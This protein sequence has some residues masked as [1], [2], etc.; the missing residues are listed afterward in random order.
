MSSE[1]RLECGVRQ[2]GLTS[3]DLFNLYVNDLIVELRSTRIGCHIGDVYINNLSYADDMVLLSPSIEGLRRLLDT[4][5]RYAEAHG[6]KYNEKK[7]EMMVFRSGKGPERVLPLFL[8]GAPVRV[9]ETFRYL[10]HVLTSDLRDDADLE[11]ERRAL[12]VRCNMLA[13]R[14]ARCTEQVKVTLFRAYCQSFYT[15]QLWLNYTKRAYSTLR[16]QYNDAFRILLKH[17]R[18][19]SASGMFAEAGVPDFFAI[20]RS[21]VAGF[22]DRV[23]SSSNTILQ[24]L[25]QLIPQELPFK[26][27]T[28]VPLPPRR[29][30]GCRMHRQVD[31]EVTNTGSTPPRR[32]AVRQC[33]PIE[34]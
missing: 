11:R 28:P 34:I 22:W 5:A 19:C 13:R 23:R 17:P 14:F 29:P 24:V 12:A 3:P 1:Y 9:V 8:R 25:L 2:G 18:F 27:C 30:P 7:T 15:C 31:T 32:R 4:C 33:I 16:V 20:M 10:G 26:K 6:L 21:R